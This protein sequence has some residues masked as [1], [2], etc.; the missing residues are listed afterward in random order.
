M[1][2]NLFFPKIKTDDIH[3]PVTYGSVD[4]RHAQLDLVGFLGDAEAAKFASELWEMMQDA[5]DQPKGIP[6]IL[7]ERKKAEIAAQKAAASK[8]V[9]TAA[10]S[11]NPL[12]AEAARRAEAARK[13]LGRQG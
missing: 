1:A 11:T 7:I 12:V 2:V 6:R 5:Q 13:A 9:A 3:A 4:P 8:E 10:K